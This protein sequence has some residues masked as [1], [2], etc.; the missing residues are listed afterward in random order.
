MLLIEFF[1]VYTKFFLKI[2]NID[3]LNSKNN[4]LFDFNLYRYIIFFQRNRNFM[5]FECSFFFV[6]RTH[7]IDEFFIVIHCK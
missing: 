2:L 7:N 3:I 5:K 1:D 4:R 6:R